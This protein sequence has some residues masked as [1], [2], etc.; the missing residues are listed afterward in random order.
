LVYLIRLIQLTAKRPQLYERVVE[1]A[2]LQGNQD[3]KYPIQDFDRAADAVHVSN[4]RLRIMFEQRRCLLSINFPSPSDNRFLGV[5]GSVSFDG[6]TA[7]PF[8]ERI[9]VFAHEVDDFEHVDV[10]SHQAC[11]IDIPRETVKDKQT[12]AGFIAVFGS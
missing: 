7:K 6:T 5:V 12:C 4:Y 3:F 8:D 1:V 11:L 2:V 9:Q 10:L